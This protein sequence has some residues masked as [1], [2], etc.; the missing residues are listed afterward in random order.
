MPGSG[1]VAKSYAT[2]GNIEARH[3]NTL[4]WGSN[5]GG[6]LVT[7]TN[8]LNLLWGP[9]YGAK[10]INQSMISVTGLPSNA[11]SGTGY[12]DNVGTLTPVAGYFT[13]QNSNNQT[14][15]ADIVTSQQWIG[16]VSALNKLLYHQNASSGNIATAPGHG[17]TVTPI[18]SYDTYLA[19]ASSNMGKARSPG[20]ITIPNSSQTYSWSAT[21]AQNDSGSIQLSILW[22]DGNQARWFFNAGGYVVFSVKGKNTL[23]NV[24]SIDTAAIFTEIGS[25]NMYGTSSTG[26]TA[27]QTNGGK[28]YWN[29]GPTLAGVAYHNASAGVYT[30]SFAQ[31]SMCVQNHSGV[32]SESGAVGCEIVFQISATSAV[33]GTFGAVDN[34]GV[35]ID[36]TVQLWDPTGFNASP[37]V[38]TWS[39]PTITNL[40]VV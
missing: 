5:V 8:N 1:Y 34:L 9:G 13:S 29:M 23:T 32:G 33:A 27:G 40:T 18:V 11:G 31:V 10:G 37:I 25:I 17:S 15:T 19:A 14:G 22:A 6:A 20:P 38:K 35:E 2:T 28:G 16:F 3:Y 12:N 26:G 39:D 21:G 36:V 24:R 7:T 4:V 30:G